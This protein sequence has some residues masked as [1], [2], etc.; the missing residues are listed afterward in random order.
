MW[1]K[2][3]YFFD[4]YLDA[5][6]AF[7]A[8]PKNPH[9]EIIQSAFDAPPKLVRREQLAAFFSQTLGQ[10]DAATEIASGDSEY[11][12]AMRA[13]SSPSSRARSWSP[14]S[15]SRSPDNPPRERSARQ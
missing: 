5:D 12:W 10:E 1:L 9:Q 13:S 6:F 8:P 11:E 2:S 3:K 15:R 7:A 4:R 14:S